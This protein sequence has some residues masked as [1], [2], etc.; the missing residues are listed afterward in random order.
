MEKVKAQKIPKSIVYLIARK[1]FY[2]IFGISKSTASSI[3]TER[4]TSYIGSQITHQKNTEI[5]H[6]NWLSQST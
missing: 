4:A 2:F 5:R 6:F 1:Y 3:D